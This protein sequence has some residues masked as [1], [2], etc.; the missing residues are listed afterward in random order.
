MS[1]WGTLGKIG[2]SIASPFTGGLSL[3]AIPGI[4]AAEGAMHG[5]GWKGALKGGAIGGAE[6]LL[7]V[8]L[9]KIPGVNKLGGGVINK[10]LGGAAPSL[11]NSAGLP[12]GAMNLSEG[13]N[14]KDYGFMGPVN[15]D[16]DF[17]GP[18]NQNLLPS[19]QTTPNMGTLPEGGV[20]LP[21]TEGTGII[22][23]LLAG[24]KNGQVSQNLGDAGEIFGGIAEGEAQNRYKKA[25]MT[26]AYDRL[27]GDAQDRQRLDQKNALI[28]AQQTAY[29]MRDGT[30]YSAPLL[31]SGQT[32]DLGYGPKATTDFEK[33][34]AATL[35]GQLM[36]RLGPN[37]SY[38]PMK[39]DY[40]DRGKIENVGQYG[41][42]GT[43]AAQIIAELLKR[44]TANGSNV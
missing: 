4:G 41:A 8:G 18:V 39:P 34:A 33:Q 10:M 29:M 13:G 35:Q 5:G 16:P 9:A 22:Q 6:A 7:P 24:F 43:S 21:N 17:M 38:M 15:Q 25:D 27:M 40:L 37:G 19:K 20:S 42:L 26:Q 28:Q 23:K 31:R 32:V 11:S 30:P 44:P 12:P 1:I 2:A 36:N 14:A 3:L